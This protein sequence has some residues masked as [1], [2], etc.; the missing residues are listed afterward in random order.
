MDKKNK[1]MHAM[2]QIPYSFKS[3]SK[4]FA[5]IERKKLPAGDYSIGGLENRVAVERKSLNVKRGRTKP[6]VGYC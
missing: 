2:E 3:F 6:N 4:W 1:K 5:A